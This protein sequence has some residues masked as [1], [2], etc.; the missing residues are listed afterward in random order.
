VTDLFGVAGR[1]LLQKLELPAPWRQS[2]DVSLHLIDELD[3]EIAE[4]A[5]SCVN[6]RPTIA[7]CRCF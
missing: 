6:R 7:T 3:L 5:R 2:V 1:E 4:L